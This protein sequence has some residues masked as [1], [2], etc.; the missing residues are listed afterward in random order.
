MLNKD[1][2]TKYKH[3][4]FFL[5]L[6]ELAADTSNNP[7]AFKMVFFG[8][9]GAVGGQAVIEILESYK[10]MT[11]ARV[12]KPTETPQLIITGINK[13][14]I[15]QFCS[16]LFQIFGKNNFKKIDEQGDESVLLFEGFLELHFKTLIAVPKFRIDLQDALSRIEDKETK[17][18]F[19][20]NEAS[21]TTSPF[22]AFI[23]DIK[24]QL[25]LKPTDKIRAVFSG[26][27][28]PSVA[29]YHFENIDRLLD[30]HGL[31]EGDPE[32]SVERSI[33]KEILKGLAE[34]FGD[35]KK[36]HAHEVLM[37]HTTSVGGMYQIIDGEPV[38]KLGYAHSSLGDLLKEKQ[39]YANELTIHYSHFMLKSLVTASAI[40]I[41]YIYANSTL[42]LS[43]GI[44]RKFRQ[45]DENKTL[46]FDLRLTQD[47]KGER[48]LNKV[49]E[50]K[51]I[52]ASHPV[53]NPKGNPT[54]KTALN[55]GNTKDN[56]P[57]LNVNYALRSGENGLF[58]LD[59]AYALYLNMKIASQE[60]LAHVLVSNALLGDDQ[61]K[62]WFDRHGICYYTQTDNSSLVFALLNN[63]KEFR[64]YQTSAFST[65]AF[66]ELG[67][68][69]HQAELHMHGLFI[70]MHK[71]RNL[72]PKQ[73]SD[74]ITSK[75]KEQE[76]K[77]W[78][79]FNT[80]K[81][82]IEDV[83]EYGKDI[84][85]L[86]KSFSDLFAIRSLEDLAKYTGFKGELKGFIKTF[87]NG[88]F[89]ALT[90]TIRSITSLGTPIIYRNAE[91]QDEILAG[92]YFAPLDLVLETNFSLLE[93]ID[94]I[95]GQHNLER[96]EFINWLVCNNGFTDL[97]PNAVFNTAK[98]Y[99]QGLT[100]QIKVIDT[101][102]AFRKAINNLK[103][104]NAR[105]TKENYH[106]NTSGLLAYCGRITGLYEQL[107][108]FD[109]SLG[110]YNGWKALFP[111][112]DHENHI[113]IPGLI[114]AMRHYA[115]GLGK[116]TGSEFLYPRYG[117]FE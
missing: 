101:S 75:Y 76:V 50:A 73:I 91:G 29:T 77:E 88:L 4:S 25:G 110:T 14:Q 79:D 97:R 58:S 42:P 62:P 38:I 43:S 83:V 78:V 111:I 82:L 67:S 28:V 3:Q 34:D 26:I 27:P 99:T 31:A 20:I 36:R 23:Q 105:N 24:I 13:A 41:D 9:T 71:L 46:P 90:T 61:Q 6:K 5:K 98:T 68:S 11:K 86:A 84:T 21:K 106:Y 55:Y 56:I 108:Q 37:A 44:S 10:Y 52:A 72:N 48:L 19:L 57:N 64:R 54:E 70:L 104:K 81:L 115:E 63:R 22:E 30:E 116:I 40:G 18:R 17:I 8:G 45:A 15:D 35:I 107:E 33:K 89:S 95:C 12:S 39:F 117:Y 100:D 49:F 112:D 16:K 51:P 103:L 85:S 66:Q 87:Y 94:Q 69:K 114:E 109:I 60:E 113:L 2:F 96:Q 1:D 65:K 32:K 80:P 92:P 93:K 102:T 53:L 47:K 74:Q 7:F 59:N